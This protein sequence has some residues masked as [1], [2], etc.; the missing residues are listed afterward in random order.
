MNPPWELLPQDI[1]VQI[2]VQL[3]LRD[4]RVAGLLKHLGGLLRG[5]AR[6]LSLLAGRFRPT[7]QIP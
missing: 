2:L 6:P 4:L 1:M 7:S 5:R 3:S